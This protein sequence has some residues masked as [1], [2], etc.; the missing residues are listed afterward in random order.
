VNGTLFF[1]ASN[2]TNGTELWKSDG[3]ATGT[4]MAKDIYTGSG[5]SSPANLTNVNGVLFFAAMG[6][7]GGTELWKST[8]TDAGTAPVKDIYPE[9]AAPVQPTLRTS[10][11]F[12]LPIT[13]ERR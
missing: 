12:L 13:N 5:G 3:T 2:G 9:T 10:P 4:V 8:G 11:M 7:T 1:A 6:T